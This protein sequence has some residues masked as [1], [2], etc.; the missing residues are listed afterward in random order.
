VLNPKNRATNGSSFSIFR[1]D[2][3]A[4]ISVGVAKDRREASKVVGLSVFLHTSAIY[5]L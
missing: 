4:S 5:K 3:Y 1:D 2:A